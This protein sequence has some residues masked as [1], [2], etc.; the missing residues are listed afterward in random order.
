TAA[1]QNLQH[2]PAD[3]K[4]PYDNDYTLQ[5]PS[6]VLVEAMKTISEDVTTAVVASRSLEE[7]VTGCASP[8][9]A[10]LAQFITNFGKRALRRPLGADEVAQIAELADKDTDWDTQVGV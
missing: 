8:S 3:E 10:C 7:R 2:W 6:D 4:R 1:L 5:N 9:A